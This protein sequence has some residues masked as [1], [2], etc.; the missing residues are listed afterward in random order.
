MRSIRVTPGGLGQFEWGF[1]A[2]L[3]V[4]GT[5]FHQCVAIAVLDN[6]FR[7]AGSAVFAA[8]ALRRGGVVSP[9]AVLDAGAEPTATAAE[10]GIPTVELSEAPASGLALNRAM[11]VAL[12]FLGL[13][14]VDAVSFLFFDFWLL[15]S[16]GLAT[17]FMTG[18]KTPPER[19]EGYL[20]AGRV[21][22][23]DLDGASYSRF[24]VDGQPIAAL[25]AGV[26]LTVTRIVDQQIVLFC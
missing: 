25:V 13:Y 14:W 21:S 15:E 11:V 1:A 23:L 2:A 24:R 17:V 10:E 8:I 6:L 7:Y 16:L 5:A 3:F 20:E 4:T 12:G 22:L 9:K 18:F 26:Q 19:C